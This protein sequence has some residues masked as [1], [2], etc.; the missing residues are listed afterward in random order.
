MKGTQVTT[1]LCF[2]SRSASYRLRQQGGDEGEQA[3]SLDLELTS[4][5][6]IYAS[7]SLIVNDAAWRMTI[8]ASN[9][10]V[11]P[12]AAS[13]WVTYSVTDSRQ[14]CLVELVQ[15]NDRFR[16]LLE[17]FKGG[18]VSEIT[19]VFDDLTSNPDYSR[20]WD[21]AG[22]ARLPISSVCFEF[23]LPLSEA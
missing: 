18:H 7:N 14:S 17:M 9:T 10:T 15:S 19:M 11:V 1:E 23:S 20:T 5:P 4:A 2:E 8:L 22:Q 13:G 21:S 16:T 12:G 3:I 6:Q